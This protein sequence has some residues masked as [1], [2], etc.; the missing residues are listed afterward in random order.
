MTHGDQDFKTS[1]S[2]Y[3]PKG[4]EIQIVEQFLDPDMIDKTV[5][6]KCEILGI[7]R[8]T[9][10]EHMK[11]PAFQVYLGSLIKDMIK[12]N[13]G[14]LVNAAVKAAKAGSFQHF[15]Y[16]MEMGDLYKEDNKLQLEASIEH[17]VTFGR[18]SDND[19]DEL[20]P[21]TIID[22]EPSETPEDSE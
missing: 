17:I 14:P 5:R 3:V 18:S 7:A 4:I 13:A 15:K 10:Y 12:V 22:I 9:Y 16:L 21:R 1:I 8:Q 11:K 6:E 19:L 20:P 2:E